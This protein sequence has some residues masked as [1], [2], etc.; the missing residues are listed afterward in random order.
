VDF[1]NF[2]Q[3]VYFGEMTFYPANGMD[4]FSP[5]NYDEILGSLLTLPEK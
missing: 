5:E 3:R 2:N 1:Y 4:V